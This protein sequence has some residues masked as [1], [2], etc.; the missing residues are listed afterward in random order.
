MN[1]IYDN[2]APE[3]KG[4]AGIIEEKIF[5]SQNIYCDPSLDMSQRD[6]SN[7]VSQISFI[8][9]YRRLSRFYSCCSFLS[10]AR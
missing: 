1:N 6:R 9:N 7:E 4:V 10:G 3:Q 2:S 5:I 8:E